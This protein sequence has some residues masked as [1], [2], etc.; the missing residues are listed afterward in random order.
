[1]EIYNFIITYTRE[2]GYPPSVREIRDA[3]GLHSTST[4]HTHLKNLEDAGLI[5]RDHSKQRSIRIC[6]GDEASET[7][8]PGRVPLVGYVAAGQPILA[9]E[10]IEDS[11]PLP[12]M[13][14][15]GGDADG[16]YMLRVNGESMINAGIRSGDVLVVQRDLSF[17]DGDIVVARVQGESATVKR[18]YREK[19][20]IRLQP[21][22]D[23]MAPILLPYDDVELDGKV[24][25]LL[26][27]Y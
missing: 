10:N 22:N 18:I 8:R 19:E 6:G 27:Q 26:R 12:P 21:E 23:H 7:S 2:H 16:V 3:V 15:H 13:L 1:M 11:F 9:V 20:H 14:L 24:I 5:W 17:S 4:V 25:G